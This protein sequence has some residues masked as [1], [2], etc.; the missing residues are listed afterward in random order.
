MKAVMAAIA[1]AG[2]GQVWAADAGVAALV[3]GP[4]RAADP[5]RAAVQCGYSGGLHAL[6]VTHTVPRAKQR[7]VTTASG[8]M[9]VSVADGYR[10]RLAFP[11][12][13]PF[14]QLKLERSLPEQFEA[15]RTAIL[16][17]L[18][19]FTAQPK[20]P[21]LKVLPA[22]GIEV[23]GLDEAALNGAGVIGVYT[24]IVPS[25]G[26]V[27]TAYLL[28]QTSARKAYADYPRYVQLRDRFL[29]ELATCLGGTMSA[30]SAAPPARSRS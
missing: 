2:A 4:V 17:Q 5:L 7:T 10:M 23:L 13:D 24:L 3:T 20:A 6:D 18:T 19:W 28:R 29:S 12:T 15:D 21:Q 26:V 30:I 8:S 1:L 16:A 27:A 22:R 25:S 11:G 14:V 9:Q